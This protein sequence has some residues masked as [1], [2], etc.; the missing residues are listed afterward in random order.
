L[1][2]IVSPQF[3]GRVGH[4]VWSGTLS[5]PVVTSYRLPLVTIGLSLTIFAVH[6]LVM[7]RQMDGIGQAKGGTLYPKVHWPPKKEK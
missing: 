2:A 7:D 3:G 4:G 6:R 1:N 5:S